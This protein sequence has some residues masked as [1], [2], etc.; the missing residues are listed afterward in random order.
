MC[1]IIFSIL[2][3]QFFF[4][5]LGM[6]LC[7][8]AN[9]MPDW[10]ISGKHDKDLLQGVARHGMARMDYYVLND[11]ELSFKDILKRHLCNEA[12]LDKKAAAE[13]EKA[14]TKAKNDLKFD[15]DMEEDEEDSVDLK[16]I[17]IQIKK[18]ERKKQMN[19]KAAEMEDHQDNNDNKKE[20]VYI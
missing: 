20:E 16:K 12:L 5:I 2:I 18:Q 3:S 15:F 1:T 14:R 6:L 10:W 11:A 13:Y 4:S 19:K 8:P 7:E 9:D 17:K